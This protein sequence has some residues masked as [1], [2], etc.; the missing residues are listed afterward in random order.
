MD[1][2]EWGGTGLLVGVL[3]EAQASKYVEIIERIDKIRTNSKAIE[4]F[5][6]SRSWR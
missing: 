2:A 6:T 1:G 5:S 4:S 3:Q